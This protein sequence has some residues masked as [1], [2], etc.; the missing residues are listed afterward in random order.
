MRRDSLWYMP[1]EGLEST[2]Q[3]PM[4]PSCQQPTVRTGGDG[5]VVWRLFTLAE[6]GPVIRMTSFVI[7]QCY[8][9]IFDD[10][11]LPFVS[12]H[13]RTAD[14]FF[15]QDNASCYDFRIVSEWLDDVRL[16]RR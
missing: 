14:L 16:Q 2:A 5:I 15:Q 9:D 1:A 3:T 4:D 8:W 11:G 13:Y 6:I 7:I 10:Y 12:L